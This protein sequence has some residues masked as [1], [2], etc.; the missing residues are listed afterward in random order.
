MAFNL[1]L[2]AVLVGGCIPILPGMGVDE[3]VKAM[4]ANAAMGCSYLHGE[5]KPP[6]S[7][8]EGA[9]IGCWGDMTPEERSLLL[10]HLK[11]LP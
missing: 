8:V 6:A 3:Q 9:V 7:S 11:G 10:E 2:L 1:V 4:K 5:G